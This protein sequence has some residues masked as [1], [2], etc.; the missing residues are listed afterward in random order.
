MRAPRAACGP[1]TA[2]LATSLALSSALALASCDRAAGGESAASRPAGAAAGA[3]ARAPLELALTTVAATPL[4]RFLRVTGT[5]H[6][7]EETT[8]AAKVAGRVEAVFAD[9]GDVVRPGQSLARIESRDQELALGERERALEQVLAPLGLKELPGAGFAIESLPSVERV[10]LQEENARARHERGKTL[11]ERVPPALS[12][13]EYADL[14]TAW[15]VSRA[16]LRAA[17]LAAETQLASA[18]AIR[19][20]V[21]SAAQRVAD[22][23]ARV[24]AGERPPIPGVAAEQT[25]TLESIVTRRHVSVGDFVQV[26]APLFELVDP[27]PL[28]LR[29][30]VPEREASR[31]RG[32]ER[33]LVRV[34]T[35]A[36]VHSGRVARVNFALDE[37]TR[38]FEVEIVV[39]N[40]DHTLR[41]GSFVRAD[42][43][44]GVDPAALVV[45][46]AAVLTFAGV[47]KVFV[48][49]DGKAS[50][51]VVQLGQELDG[52]V[53]ITRG[54]A[55][56]DTI[57]A[58][59]P[60]DLVS[61][62][63]VRAAAAGAA[64]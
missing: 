39:P 2:R 36:G 42:I 45:P 35:D 18:R 27:D 4:P 32:G 41:A 58:Q 7:E 15:E 16:D 5:F 33:A 54:L 56:G 21:E 51:S 9:L 34:D 43:E 62:V 17:V 30:A 31:V 48:V 23:L 60:Q 25:P 63:P 13:Q 50:E 61:G 53:E 46:R 55:A 26:G 52:R 6:G 57:A 44:T 29:A 22:T 19:A 12:D 1:R 37:R 8:V 38:T 11:H 40:P 28:K 59:P 10:R 14:Q 47:H 24:P 49:R 64:R 20:Q 3:V